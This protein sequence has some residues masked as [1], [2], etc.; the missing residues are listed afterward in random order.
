M[1][2]LIRAVRLLIQNGGYPDEVQ[3]EIMPDTLVFRT[4]HEGVSKKGETTLRSRNIGT[5][6]ALKKLSKH[7]LEPWTPL[8]RQLRLIVSVRDKTSPLKVIHPRTDHLGTQPDINDAVITS[9]SET[10]NGHPALRS[11]LTVTTGATLA[12]C[13]KPGKQMS[14]KY[15]GGSNNQGEQGSE[16][17]VNFPRDDPAR[18]LFLATLR[19][20]HP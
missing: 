12:K 7:S 14:V 4:E 13:A 15:K 9:I 17:A 18:S 1:D 19:A 8:Y 20:E 5:H 11:V 10:S 3:C 6:R 16:G 2:A